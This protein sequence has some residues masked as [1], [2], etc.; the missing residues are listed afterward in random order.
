MQ[1]KNIPS[2]SGPQPLSQGSAK[3]A[4]PSPRQRT[5]IRTLFSRVL[6]PDEVDLLIAVWAAGNVRAADA[7]NIAASLLRRGWI[8]R[9]GEF[10]RFSEETRI[11]LTESRA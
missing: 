5:R 11:L 4:R 7:P 3:S 10:V 9:D 2:K 1:M 6:H 8:E